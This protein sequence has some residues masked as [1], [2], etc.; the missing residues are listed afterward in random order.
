MTCELVLHVDEDLATHVLLLRFRLV[1]LKDKLKGFS[2]IREGIFLDL[3]SAYR[4][5]Q[6]AASSRNV[7]KLLGPSLDDL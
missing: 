3:A 7:A 2:Q 6:L 5:R 4:F 1:V